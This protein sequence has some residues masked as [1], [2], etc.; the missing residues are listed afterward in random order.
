MIDLVTVP[1]VDSTLG[2]KLLPS[3]LGLTAGTVDVIGFLALG[4]LFAAHITGSLVILAAHLVNG[5][6]LPLAHILSLPVFVAVL[7][8]TRLSASGLEAAGLA[9]LRPLLALQFVLLAVALAL[10]VAA[11]TPLDPAAPS[12]VIAAMLAVA[13]MAVQNT[14]VQISLKG[15][16]STAVM[17]TNVTRFMADVGTVLLGSDP[18]EVAG[19][20]QRARRTWPAIVGFAAGCGLG[21][22]CENAYGPWALSLPAGLALCAL[23]LSVGVERDRRG[24]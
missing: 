17:T 20:R 13:A 2:T 4:G 21:A 8:L 1:S 24:R 11:G 6:A 3:V 19:A 22:A 14:L 7:A 9:S 18:R 23:A 10:C 15:A 12:A 5:G 16:P